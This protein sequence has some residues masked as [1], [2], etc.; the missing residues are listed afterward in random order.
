M[1]R[2]RRGDIR[3]VSPP[4]F[5]KPR[6]A[7]IVSIDPIND[8]R[9][10]ILAVPITTHAAPLRVALPEARD[11]TGLRVASYAKC[12]SVGPLHKSHLKSR[13]GRLPLDAWPAVEAGLGRVLGLTM[14][15]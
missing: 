11:A 8:L 2:I 15:A 5:P 7:L 1:D 13:M 9:P 6:P 3:T 10:D 14:N 4:A 12:E